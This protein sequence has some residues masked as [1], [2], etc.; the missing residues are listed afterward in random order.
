VAKPAHELKAEAL[1]EIGVLLI[2][3]G[4]VDTFFNQGEKHWIAA[5]AA[6]CVGVMLVWVGIDMEA[7]E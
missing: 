6:L 3:F 1:R 5:I 4:P 2:V 7:P